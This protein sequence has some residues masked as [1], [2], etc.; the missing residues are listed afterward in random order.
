VRRDRRSK[1]WKSGPLWIF[2]GC[3]RETVLPRRPTQPTARPPSPY[4]ESGSHG[5]PGGLIPA[6]LVHKLGCSAIGLGQVIPWEA[7]V[8]HNRAAL[9]FAL[10]R[11]AII[12]SMTVL[13]IALLHSHTRILHPYAK[14]RLHS[15]KVPHGTP[16]RDQKR[17]L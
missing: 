6:L 4:E 8:N 5:N 17:P 9:W 11:S 7:S 3:S 13:P 1:L 14:I 16:P 10:V 12:L 15:L 2:L